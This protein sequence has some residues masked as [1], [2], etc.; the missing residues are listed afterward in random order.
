[1]EDTLKCKAGAR[2]AYPR[3]RSRDQVLQQP[4][5]L[6][7]INSQPNNT[8]RLQKHELVTLKQKLL[9]KTN[10]ILPFETTW[11]VSCSVK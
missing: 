1:M 2:V 8:L 4:D 5:P 3:R 7:H 10:E 11:I 6:A 9:F